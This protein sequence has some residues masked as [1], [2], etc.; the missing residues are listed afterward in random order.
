[1]DNFSTN[2]AMVER[3][4]TLLS[5]ES[6]ILGCNFFHMRFAAHILNLIVKGGLSVIESGIACVRDSVS[7]WSSSPKMDG[8]V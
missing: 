3:L 8:K 1:M 7:Y 4:K 6:M 5:T 2:D